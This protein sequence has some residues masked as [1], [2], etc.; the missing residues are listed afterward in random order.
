MEWLQYFSSNV[1]QRKTN[2]VSKGELHFFSISCNFR[3]TNGQNNMFVFTHFGL[4]PPLWEILDPP[5]QGN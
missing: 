5:L 1:Q 2:K 4:A 3:E